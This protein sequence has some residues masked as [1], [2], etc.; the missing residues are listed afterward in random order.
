MQVIHC[1]KVTYSKKVHT[2]KR[3]LELATG[4]FLHIDGHASIKFVYLYNGCN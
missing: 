1:N 3:C 4:A 2:Y